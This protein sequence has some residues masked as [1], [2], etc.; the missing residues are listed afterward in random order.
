MDQPIYFDNNATTRV[1]PEVREAMR[2]FLDDEYANPSSAYGF[3][4]RSQDA[5][6][7]AHERVASLLGA[8]PGEIVMTSCGTESDATAI[9]SALEAFPEKRRF[10]TT[11]V[12]HPAI[13]GAAERLGGK[14]YDVR[15]LGVDVKGRINLDELKE[16]LTEDTAL[17]SIMLA[18]NET[19]VIYPVAEAGAL[20]GERGVLFHTDAVQAAGK[21]RINLAALPVDYFSLSGHKLHAPKGVGARYVRRGAPFFPLLV[22]GHQEYGRRA[23]TQAVPN[24]VALG[25]ACELAEERLDRE[26]A[27][28]AALR[29]SLQRRLLAAI[30]E[31]V[32]NGDEDCRL[33]NTLNMAFKGVESQ[34][35]VAGLDRLGICVSSGSACTEHKQEPSHVMRAMRVPAEYANGAVRISLSGFTTERETGILA[36]ALPRLIRELRAE[37]PAEGVCLSA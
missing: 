16:Q 28:M 33:P 22:G 7:E 29:D 3:A 4:H 25:K 8:R 6:L 14:G 20:C 21:L 10:I 9:F 30:P 11:S 23:G 27:A 17:V 26:S 18:N 1:A 37:L 24:I 32:V 35:L 19:G 13:L 2:P 34:S 5:L 36:E 12:E 31:A 15:Y